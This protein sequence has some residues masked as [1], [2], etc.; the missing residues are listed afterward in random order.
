MSL[1]GTRVVDL[2]RI[3]AGPFCTQLLGDLGADVIKVETPSGDPMRGQGAI[4]DG[5]SWYF[6]GFN[7]NKRSV[8]LNLRSKEG[9]EVLKKMISNSD[10]LVEN[11]KA[12][13]LAKMGLCDNTLK[14]LNPRLIVCHISG[15]GKDGPYSNRP[16]FD[17]V[18]QAMSGFMWTNG[19]DGD[20]PLRS[21][22]PISDLV[23]GL[24]G[25]LA[26]S[27]ALTVPVEKREFKSI[28]VCLMDGLVSLFA[29]MGSE[30]L[31]TGKPLDR[32][33]N[34]H[35]LVAPYGLYETADS[36]IA[37]APSNEIIFSRLIDTLDR[38]DLKNDPRFVDNNAR[39]QHRNEIREELQPHFLKKTSAEWI[40]ILNEKGVPAG[41]VKS[42]EE[43][44]N[45]P[46]VKHRE[47]VIDVPHPGHGTVRMLGFPIKQSI[48]APKLRRPAPDMGQHNTE[49]LAD[50]G[51]SAEDVAR[52]LGDEVIAS[53][54]MLQA[55]Q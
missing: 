39:V 5:M 54:A 48:D 38:K 8:G 15:F 34:D 41:S 14:E 22:L 27:S 44:L 40:N 4:R 2:T 30:Q 23:V 45:D 53:D 33:G 9:M 17:F 3:I 31:A 18:V 37:I 10:V 46:Q 7:R 35:P 13:T 25:S 12:G 16:A 24:Y 55:A 36:H 20:E 1:A 32:S 28:D 11:Y 19:Y 26:V 43:A 42:V 52:L 50:L 21:G 47:M 51:Y 49:V 29:Y 6:A